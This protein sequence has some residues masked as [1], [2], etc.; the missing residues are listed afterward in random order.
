M[1]YETLVEDAVA[2]PVEEVAQRNPLFIAWDK[3][4][5]T[6][7]GSRLHFESDV[8]VVMPP[9]TTAAGEAA[10][11]SF[12]SSMTQEARGSSSRFGATLANEALPGTG[13]VLSSGLAFEFEGRGIVFF[14]PWTAISELRT[15][16]G[17]LRYV[18]CPPEPRVPVFVDLMLASPV[19]SGAVA[20]DM[21]ARCQAFATL[22]PALGYAQQAPVAVVM[23][24]RVAPD[25]TL[26]RR[27]RIVACG[28]SLFILC[29]LLV[30]GGIIQFI[31][32]GITMPAIVA[33]CPSW[34]WVG[35]ASGAAEAGVGVIFGFLLL[36]AKLAFPASIAMGLSILA[37]AAFVLGANTAFY[38][39]VSVVAPVTSIFQLVV[40]AL[41]H[42]CCAVQAF[43]FGWYT[44][45]DNPKNWPAGQYRLCTYI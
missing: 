8:R 36:R 42:V 18:F 45:K 34:T 24:E 3:S 7:V 13:V 40:G 4:V 1:S 5:L 10:A 2:V 31:I 16:P 23:H 26:G 12:R 38:V 37:M 17:R 30:I 44:S 19:H 27:Q 32:W 25:P 22:P 28:R 41:C 43:W 20:A 39:G 15:S 35:W 14:H 29:I 33:C 9:S 6:F 11:D 21:I